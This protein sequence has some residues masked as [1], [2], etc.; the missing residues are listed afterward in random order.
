MIGQTYNRY[1]IIGNINNRVALAVNKTSVEPWAVW[2]L[3]DNGNPYAGSYFNNREAALR[4][5]MSR[6]FSGRVYAEC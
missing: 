1:T 4:E 2:W 6:A 5:F 3:D